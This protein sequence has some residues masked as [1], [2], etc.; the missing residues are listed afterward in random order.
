MLL[1]SYDEYYYECP[2]CFLGAMTATAVTRMRAYVYVHVCIYI[3]IYIYTHMHTYTCM[4]VF[5]TNGGH[6]DQYCKHCIYCNNENA[7]LNYIGDKAGQHH[8][9][10]PQ[11]LWPT[12]WETASGY[13]SKG[14]CSRRGVQW[15]GVVSYSKAAYNIMQIAT[16]CFHCTPL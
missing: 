5:N 8:A 2:Q 9:S 6:T 7:P 11:S 3:Y 10:S 13:S 16:P 12:G 14:W 4:H 15:M 1:I